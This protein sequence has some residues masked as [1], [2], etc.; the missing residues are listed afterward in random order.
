VRAQARAK[1]RVIR[2]AKCTGSRGYAPARDDV[3]GRRLAV[4]KGH[5]VQRDAR[6]LDALARVPA[7][8]SAHELLDVGRGELAQAA[9]AG[10][11]VQQRRRRLRSSGAGGAAAAR[12]GRSGARRRKRGASQRRSAARGAATH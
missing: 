1:A 7:L 12:A 5:V 3:V 8:A 11:R 6:R 10:R 4:G 2:R 9:A